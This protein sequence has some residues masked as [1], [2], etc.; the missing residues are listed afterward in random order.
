MLNHSFRL[1]GD[2]RWNWLKH[3]GLS[4]LKYYAHDYI[5]I[6]QIVLC[7][8]NNFKHFKTMEVVCRFSR[9]HHLYCTQLSSH[10]LNMQKVFNL[11]SFCS[12]KINNGIHLEAGN[13]GSDEE[14]EG[15]KECVCAGNGREANAW[16]DAMRCIY[17][18]ALFIALLSA[19]KRPKQ[20]EWILC[21][22]LSWSNFEMTNTICNMYSQYHLASLSLS[23]PLSMHA[24]IILCRGI[25]A[26][27]ETHIG[28]CSA[29]CT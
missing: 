19:I 20:S 15:E 14:A 26:R 8:F 22:A 4:R 24:M 12:F 28:G 13:S 9:F 18:L 25:A 16:D 11:Y 5:P 3:I 6:V 23:L 2:G 7:Q 21:A 27:P 10:T 1:A 29:S 17:Y